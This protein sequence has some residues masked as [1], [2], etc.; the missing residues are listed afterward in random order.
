MSLLSVHMGS[1]SL[2]PHSLDHMEKQE[3]LVATGGRCITLVRSTVV[4]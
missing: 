1:G 2:S 3:G 4:R